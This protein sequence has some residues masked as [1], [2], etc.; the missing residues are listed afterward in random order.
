MSTAE[1]RAV[2]TELERHY[3]AD[4][5]S[6]TWAALTD[7]AKDARGWELANARADLRLAERAEFEASKRA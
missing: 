6:P 5:G 2:L 7:N 3:I 1:A 4:R